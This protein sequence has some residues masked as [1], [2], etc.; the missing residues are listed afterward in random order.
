MHGRSQPVRL[1]KEFRLEGRVRQQERGVVLEPIESDAGAW[2]A[3]LDAHEGAFMEEG[4]GQPS[5]PAP[6]DALDA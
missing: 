3:R 6:C 2:F 5:M 4:R 1:P